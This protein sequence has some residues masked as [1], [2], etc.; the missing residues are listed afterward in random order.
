MVC[1]RVDFLSWSMLFERPRSASGTNLEA[2]Q[3]LQVNIFT[4]P[5]FSSEENRQ[6]RTA[7]RHWDN[8]LHIRVSPLVLE[9]QSR[10]LRIDS[11]FRTLKVIFTSL[12]V[13]LIFISCLFFE[14]V[15]SLYSQ[16]RIHL[17][18]NLG[19]V[20]NSQF[21]CLSLLSANGYGWHA[22]RPGII[23]MIEGIIFNFVFRI[24]IFLLILFMHNVQFKN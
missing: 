2:A 9:F 18:L 24:S 3:L 13:W 23:L 19:S 22:A 15:F 16:P 4:L 20:L 7:H 10:K 17:S 1:P 12:T 11:F 14:T 6:E 21:C 8:L 5:P